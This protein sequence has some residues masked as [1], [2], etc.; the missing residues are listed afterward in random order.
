MISYNPRNVCSLTCR[1]IEYNSKKT[2]IQ[3]SNN[4]KE[5]AFLDGRLFV[6]NDC[7]IKEKAFQIIIY[8]AVKANNCDLT[9][10]NIKYYLKQFCTGNY[11]LQM[12]TTAEGVLD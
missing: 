9:R 8:L 5:S 4:E 3:V 2:S 6:K 1:S 11:V 10:N 12:C 7:Q